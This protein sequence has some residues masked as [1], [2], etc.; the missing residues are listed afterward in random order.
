MIHASSLLLPEKKN[1]VDRKEG[2]EAKAF[3]LVGM[4]GCELS[5]RAAADPVR[6]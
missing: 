6:F 2:N 4:N 3:S 1:G 5:P